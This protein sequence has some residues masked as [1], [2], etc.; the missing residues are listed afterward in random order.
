MTTSHSSCPLDCPDACSLDVEVSDGRVTAVRG[1][2][3]SEL[4]AGFICTK[5]GRLA[6]H[7]YCPERVLHPQLRT[8]PKG[9][10]AFR[11]AS[12]DEALDRIAERLGSI[13]DSHGGEAILPCSYGG[14]NGW[15]TEGSFDARLF[16]RLGACRLNRNLCALPSSAAA[17]AVYGKM[18]GLRLQDFAL[19]RYI[20]VWGCNPHA[21][22]IHLLPHLKAARKAGARLVVVDPRRTRLAADADL[23]LAVRPGTDLPLALAL[24]RWLFAH[25]RADQAFLAEHCTG[26]EELRALA[27]PWTPEAAAAECGLDQKDIVALAQGLADASPAA[28]RCG[29][30]SERNRNGA[31]ATAAIL[32]LPAVA[33]KFG[34]PGGGFAMSSSGHWGRVGV[35]AAVGARQPTTRRIDLTGVGPALVTDDRIRA[36]FVYNCNPLATLPEQASVRAGLL[37][38]DLFTV[39]HEQ[40]MTDTAL[41]A[42]VVL[43]A[44]TF[45]E[46]HEVHRGY[47]N[48]VLHDRPA[49]V[50]PVGEAR[51]NGWVFQA[52]VERLGLDEPGELRTPE[53]LAHALR[54]A[55][56]APVD[57]PVWEPTVSDAFDGR[58]PG[59]PDGKVHLVPGPGWYAY[60]PDPATPTH[61]LALI[62]PALADQITSTFG[63]LRS[64]PEPVQ[65]HPV[66]AAARGLADGDPAR[67]F[68]DRG[69][70][71]V[72]VRVTDAVRAGTLCLPKGLWARHTL[73]GHGPNALAPAT[74]SDFGEGACYNDARVQLEPA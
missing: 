64:G 31:S 33:G 29:W 57:Q 11:Q 65:V 20:V 46:H 37:R 2:R 71:R 28:I 54:T 36:L 23:H 55:A 7:L 43:P 18:P 24:H 21:T 39:V 19:S 68:N 63:Q 58:F 62:S 13:R 67:V 15:L 3:A 49:A 10:G 51:P 40:V 56:G 14:S 17:A 60:Q 42:D 66:D 69:E 25:D 59:T 8:G 34:V 72:P 6:D 35:A 12:W 47:G 73:D 44:T 22:G 27:E 45:V 52:L 16:A 41:Y 5:V 48:V 53:E 50:A 30:G 32:A 61:P 9:S 70:V 4:T 74:L 1:N 38:E 26:A